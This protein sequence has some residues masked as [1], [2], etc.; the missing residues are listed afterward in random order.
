[1]KEK[2]IISRYPYSYGY[3]IEGKGYKTEKNAEKYI[4]LFKARVEALNEVQQ[5][6]FKEDIV[7]NRNEKKYCI[8][9][10]EIS[11]KFLNDK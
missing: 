1:M 9:D 11:D 5:K 10:I 6:F 7:S 8:V 2:I 4:R 3:Q